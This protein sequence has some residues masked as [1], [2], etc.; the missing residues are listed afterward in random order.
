MNEKR[1][2]GNISVNVVSEDFGNMNGVLDWL[3]PSGQ[4][5]FTREENIAAGRTWLTSIYNELKPN[6]SYSTFME[7]LMLDSYNQKIPDEDFLSFLDTIGFSVNTSKEISDKVKA[8]LVKSLSA[9]K[10]MLPSRKSIVSAFLDPNNMK[11]TYWDAI[12]VTASQTATAAAAAAKDTAAVV[13]GGL[14]VL[15]FIVKYR[16]PIIIAAAVGVGYFLYQNRSL[17][18]E[19]IKEKGLKTLG[20]GE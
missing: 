14:S 6:A 15:G 1:T 18:G 5:K 16:T 3:F 17:V 10:N 13:S 4:K 12:K 20:L 9:N 19:R 8:S 2:L 11:W 7:A